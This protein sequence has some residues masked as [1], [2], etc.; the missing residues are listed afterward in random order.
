MSIGQ[1]EIKKEST[2]FITQYYA[3][4]CMQRNYRAVVASAQ[5]INKFCIVIKVVCL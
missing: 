4:S 1:P 3:G 5:K 2:I